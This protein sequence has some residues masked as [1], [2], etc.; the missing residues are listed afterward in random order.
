MRTDG[1]IVYLLTGS[2][3]NLSIFIHAAAI[4]NNNLQ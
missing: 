4:H 1:T 2:Y 3:C